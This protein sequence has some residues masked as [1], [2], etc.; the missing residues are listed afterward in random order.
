M[1]AACASPRAGRPTTRA[2]EI[3]LRCAARPALVNTADPV[4]W[5]AG[6]PD[7]ATCEAP[8][9]YREIRVT[10]EVAIVYPSDMLRL[11]DDD[12][13]V[14]GAIYLRYPTGAAEERQ[15]REMYPTCVPPPGGERRGVCRVRL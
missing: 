10:T 6:L 4:G 1:A 13:T 8:P 15:M 11:V 2:P 12:G 3:V 14:T 7:L 9:A 5:I